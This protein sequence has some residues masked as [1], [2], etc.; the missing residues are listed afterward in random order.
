MRVERDSVPR[1]EDP[2]SELER[3]LI[4]DFLKSHG[5]ADA[6]LNVLSESERTVVLI[7]AHRY[8]AARLAEMEARAH[9]L[10]EIHGL[11]AG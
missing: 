5:Y 2:T 8:A 6:N 1:L 4:H 11:K 3:A 9:Y 7:Q 10:H